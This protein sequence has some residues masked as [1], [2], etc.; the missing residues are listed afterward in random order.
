MSRVSGLLPRAAIG[1][2]LLY[3]CLV[4]VVMSVYFTSAVAV[5]TLWFGLEAASLTF[6]SKYGGMLSL[7]QTGLFGVAGLTVA[8]L[9]VGLGWNG[10]LGALV[11]IAVTAA[12]GFILGAVASGTEGIYFLML[13]LAYG[14]VIYY[15][16]GAVPQF[17]AHEGINSIVQPKIL[18]DPVLHPLR[19]YYFAVVV[20]LLT[21]LFIRYMATTP[22]GLALQGVRDDPARMTALGYNVRLSRTIAFTIGATVAAM[23]GV[24]SAWNDTRMSAD[25]LSLT[26]AIQ[27]LTAAVIGGIGRLEGAW[28]GAFVVTMLATY[29]PGYTARFETVIGIILLGVLLF[30]PS[31]LAGGVPGFGR[32]G[33]GVQRERLDVGLLSREV[34]DG[35]DVSGEKAGVP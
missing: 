34:G 28:A 7:A 20:C 21:Y 15:F 13:T 19:S 24:L 16:F 32:I 9:T 33:A 6:L 18:G 26:V 25:S 11:A 3:I 17:G 5:T 10:W 27:V 31:G 2:L 12:A 8:K 23:A 35:R 4:P 14:E 29:T 1:G 22:F 30:W